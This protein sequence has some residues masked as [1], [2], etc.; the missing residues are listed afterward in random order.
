MPAA[1]R[2]AR[3]MPS[4]RLLIVLALL[5]PLFLVSAG[6][7]LLADVAALGIALWDWSRTER[8]TLSREGPV[9][10][11]LGAVA[12]VRI[13]FDAPFAQPTT[14]ALTDDLSKG[15]ERI[16]PTTPIDEFG[17]RLDGSDSDDPASDLA[18]IPESANDSDAAVRASPEPIRIESP[19][20]PEFGY[21]VRARARGRQHLGDLHL[22]VR[23]P[24]GLAWRQW[25]LPAD[26]AVHVQPGAEEH[27][28]FRVLSLR[29]RL[30][31]GGLHAIRER[32][33]GQS[34]E[35]LREYQRGDDPRKMD[36]KATA[37][38]GSPII[39]EYE[40]ERSQSIMIA[41]D[42]GRLM[43]ERI[44]DRERVDY[45][46]SGAVLL[47]DVARSY[48]DRVGLLVF[49]DAVRHFIPP[50]RTRVSSIAEA[51]G[52]VETRLVEPNYPLAF[53]FLGH[54]LKRRSL[55]VFFTDLIDGE[56]SKALVAQ[57]S[58]SARAHLPLAVTLRNPA[59][60]EAAQTTSG[61]HHVY[62][63]AAAE[64][65]IQARSLALASMRR[66]GVL[67]VDAKPW[68]VIP[69]TANRYLDVKRRGLL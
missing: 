37:R 67:V 36:W 62:T 2:G 54:A 42:A 34:F 18:A 30:R 64:E 25:T 46:L 40:A 35:S 39:R 28:R 3:P 8:P 17:I 16:R 51:L 66:S 32:G 12:P 49:N 5:S 6:V 11:S 63:R 41:I 27:R 65:L 45:A 22:R 31:E 55:I 48:G 60:E 43:A 61:R 9:R 20:P 50:R 69:E 38:R 24:L 33:V 13:R 58:R 10:L 23:S 14:L 59:L 7:A 29:H 68:D 26:D 4:G 1:P 56:A 19:Y 53:T 15:L 21:V 44:G 57:I 52:S 47:T